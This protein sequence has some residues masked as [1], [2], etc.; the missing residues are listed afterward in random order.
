MP[1]GRS[2]TPARRRPAAYVA[3]PRARWRRWCSAT[4][5]AAGIDARDLRGAGRAPARARAS[6]SSCFEQPW[7]VA[8]QKVATAAADARRR[9]PRA[10]PTCCAPARPLVVGGRVGRRPLGGPHARGARRRGLPGA[11][12]PA[13]PARPAR[14]SP[15]STELHGR[16]RADAG[17][18]GRA[19]PVRPARG[20]P[21]RPRRS[22]S[23]CPAADHGLKVPKSRAALSQDEALADRRRGD[24]GV[25][26]A[27]GRRESTEPGVTRVPA[28]V[29]ATP[30]KRRARDARR[31]RRLLLGRR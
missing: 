5:P 9:A 26:G 12:L 8:G 27:R 25:G 6:R 19:R 2:P 30:A 11:V 3:A 23:W 21:R 31:R 18:P 13:A 1:S 22:T 17:G 28:G 24:A 10:P 15:G 20:V 16:R 14:R 7:R 29:T 4:A